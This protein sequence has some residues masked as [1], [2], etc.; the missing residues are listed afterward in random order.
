MASALMTQERWQK[1]QEVFD[2][3]A[4][5][6]PQE[7]AALLDQV[8]KED[9]ELRQ[10]VE[11]LLAWEGNENLIKNALDGAAELLRPET[12]ESPAGPRLGRQIGVYRLTAII[13]EGGMGVVYKA[14]DSRLNRT[15]ALKFLNPHLNLDP[16]AKE[17]FLLEARAAAALEHPNICTIHEIGETA[18]GQLF[19]AMAWYDGETLSEK[20]RHGPLPA[21][22]AVDIAL[23]MAQGL[24]HA[25][26]AGIVHRDIKPANVMVTRDGVVKLLDFGVAK[27]TGVD[28]TQAPV[29][30]GTPA[31]MSPE[32]VLGRGV[33]RRSDIWSLG[34]VLYEMFTGQ[35]PFRGDVAA[36]LHSITSRDPAPIARS[37]SDVP[38]E[39]ERIVSK[40]LARDPQ[41]R[42]G[43]TQELVRDLKILR[44][45]PERAR[46]AGRRIFPARLRR[47]AWL[48]GAV[49]LL[50]CC[51]QRRRTTGSLAVSRRLSRPLQ[52]CHS[53]T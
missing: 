29:V 40:T 12:A 30:P 35:P 33:D 14:H 28:L 20:V 19:I 11:S 39:L 6:A 36:V 2:L 13:G 24:E 32:Q 49:P 10:E 15:V 21:Q 41:N 52:C 38:H 27:M 53:Q 48:F 8:C 3:V 16:A 26:A 43:N 50:V 42:Y 47:H 25:H 31:Y 18:E 4:G 37:R 9:L 22:E 45:D 51:W 46:G 1:V 44:D 7:R 5:R 23:Q 34:A 17:R